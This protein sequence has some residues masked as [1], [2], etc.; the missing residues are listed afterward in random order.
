MAERMAINAPIQGTEGDIVKIAM[1]NVHEYLQKEK[2]LDEV[3]L[4]LQVHDELVFEI[5]D[6]E[7]RKVVPKIRK[8]ME[9]VFEGKD[10][11]GVPVITE[12]EVGQNWGEME[13]FKS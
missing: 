7:I 1:K 3:R 13:D 8:I 11:Q 10:T 12:V 2:L 6:T 9:E 4:I 5:K